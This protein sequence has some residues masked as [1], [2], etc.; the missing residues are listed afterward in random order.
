MD[1]DKWERLNRTLLIT[2]FKTYDKNVDPE[3]DTYRTW[4]K[5]RWKDAQFPVPKK[6]DQ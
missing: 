1:F 2:F 5:L 6:P 4:A 3:D